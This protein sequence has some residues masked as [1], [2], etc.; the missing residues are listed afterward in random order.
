MCSRIWSVCQLA[1]PQEV[2]D[3]LSFYPGAW[4][5]CR[6]FSRLHPDLS[7]RHVAG[8]YAALSPMNT[9]DTNVANMLDAVR[10][11]KEHAADPAVTVGLSSVR[12][13][14]TGYASDYPVVNTTHANR[15]KALRIALGDDPES[16][17]SGRKVLSF[18]RCISSPDDPSLPPAIDRHMFNLALGLSSPTKREQG[19]IAHDSALY[20]RVEAAFVDMGRREGIGN[21]LASICWFVQRRLERTGQ[22]ALEPAGGPLPP[23]PGPICCGRPM[24]RHG[25]LKARSRRA[26]W[27]TCTDLVGTP[28]TK[29]AG[30]HVRIA[31]PGGSYRWY[32]PRCRSTRIPEYCLRLV[33]TPSDSGSGSGWTQCYSTQGYKLWRDEKGR[34]CLTLPKQHLYS[35]S[36]GYQRLARFLVAEELGYLPPSSQHTHHI[37]GLSDDSLATLELLDVAYH[38][39]I[40]ASALYV[41]RSED[42]RFKAIDDPG[43]HGGIFSWP[44]RG[45]VLG[46][47]ARG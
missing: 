9:W 47:A 41:A 20:S 25:I 15:D 1:T 27:P 16:V 32:C 40:H 39:C 37:R 26:G 46:R 12:R 6:F 18:F 30:T 29:G 11:A 21:R 31:E 38:G 10:W 33:R 14:Y 42:G 35:N 2:R 3:G 4:G 19:N 7:P 45:A 34:C 23:L 24:W 5:L 28:A 36:A 13:G 17:L 43:A 8:I 44:R 22:R